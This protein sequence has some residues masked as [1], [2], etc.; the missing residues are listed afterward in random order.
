MQA[1]RN[2][3]EP[4]LGEAC[5]MMRVR[6]FDN[7]AVDDNEDAAVDC[8]SDNVDNDDDANGNDGMTLVPASMP[9]ISLPPR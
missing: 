6:R 7:D 2:V 5:S 4:V 9:S 8:V 1:L 3:V